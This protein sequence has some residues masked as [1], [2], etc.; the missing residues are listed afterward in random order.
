MSSVQGGICLGIKAVAET[1][2]F[3]TKTQ[4]QWGSLFV[5]WLKAELGKQQLFLSFVGFVWFLY[6]FFLGIHC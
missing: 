2:T 6:R 4:I 5:T 1:V 3:R